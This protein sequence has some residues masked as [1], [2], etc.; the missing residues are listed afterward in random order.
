MLGQSHG[1]FL[2]T[3]LHLTLAHEVALTS[4]SIN[5]WAGLQIRTAAAELYN[6]HRCLHAGQD[7]SK[8][9]DTSQHLMPATM[10]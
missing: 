3:V 2:R 9:Q 5:P 1:N 8:Y 4:S 6:G 7:G 10:S